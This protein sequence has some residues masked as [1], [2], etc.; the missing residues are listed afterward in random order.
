MRINMLSAKNNYQDVAAVI[1]AMTDGKQPFLFETVKA[2]L[3]D[4]CIS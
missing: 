3:S 2:V 1:T 4:P